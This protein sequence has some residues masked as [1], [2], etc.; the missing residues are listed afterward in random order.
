[1]PE[2]K[3][4]SC[5]YSSTEHSIECS[6]QCLSQAQNTISIPANKGYP[7]REDSHP[8]SWVY[9][10]V[11]RWRED[12][13]PKVVPTPKQVTEPPHQ[14]HIFLLYPATLGNGGRS[15]RH[16]CDGHTDKGRV[17]RGIERELYFT[18]PPVPYISPISSPCRL[19]SAV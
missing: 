10:R 18:E 15:S 11:Y 6:L 4:S 5:L 19:N 17:E 2:Y 7:W 9:Q 8:R 16:G 13:D 12:S 14:F 3:I 1:M